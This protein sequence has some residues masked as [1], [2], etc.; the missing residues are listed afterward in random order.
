ME[1]IRRARWS[2]GGWGWFSRWVWHPHG[3][4]SSPNPR[5]LGVL[6]RFHYVVGIIDE[7]LGCCQLNSILVPFS[8]S[9]GEG[10]ESSNLIT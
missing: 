3:T 4:G 10:V 8:L 5:Y 2:E 6:L 1:E 7:I 9:G